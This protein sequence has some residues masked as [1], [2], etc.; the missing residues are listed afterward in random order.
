MKNINGLSV[1]TNQLETFK[2][3]CCCCNVVLNDFEST[4]KSAATGDYLDM[5]NKCYGFVEKDIPTVGRTDL[6]PLEQDWEED[7]YGENSQLESWGDE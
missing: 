7:Y 4:R 3:R 2:M 6:N 5:C 1:K